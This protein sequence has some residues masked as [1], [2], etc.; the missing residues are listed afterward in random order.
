MHFEH[1]QLCLHVPRLLFFG[2]VYLFA[3]LVP[4]HYKN[5]CFWGV[6]KLDIQLFGLKNVGLFFAQQHTQIKIKKTKPCF[7]EFLYL[8]FL[9]LFFS[10]FSVCLSIISLL[11]FLPSFLPSFLSLPSFL[12]LLLFAQE[13]PNIYKTKKPFVYRYVLFCLSLFHFTFFLWFSFFLSV[14][15]LFP[16]LPSF[17]PFSSFFPS[18]LLSFFSLASFI[19]SFFLLLV[20]LPSQRSRRRKRER[21]REQEDEEEQRRRKRR[22]LRTGQ[23]EQHKKRRR[24]EKE[25]KKEKQ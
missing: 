3:L 6:W 1:G 9:S 13:H 19:L 16:F 11:S 10:D 23:E 21:E 14:F 2:W 25:N 15:P 8:C 18:F 4:N 20:L 17:L 12:L 22:R 24:R 5:R 7:P